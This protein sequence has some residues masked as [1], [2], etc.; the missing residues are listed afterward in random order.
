VNDAAPAHLFERSLG[1][2][3]YVDHDLDLCA[4]NGAPLRPGSVTLALEASSGRLPVI[5]LHDVAVCSRASVATAGFHARDGAQRPCRPLR[6]AGFPAGSD[7]VGEVRFACVASGAG[8]PRRSGSSCCGSPATPTTYRNGRS[9]KGL[10]R[11][12]P[13]RPPSRAVRRLAAERA[14]LAKERLGGALVRSG[15]TGRTG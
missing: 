10:G 14:R 9:R 5:R 2:R 11:E 1:G 15:Q 12:R 6:C 8:A 13:K 7:H 4:A 3:G